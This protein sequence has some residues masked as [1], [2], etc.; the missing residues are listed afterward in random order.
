MKKNINFAFLSLV[1]L[2]LARIGYLAVTHRIAPHDTFYRF[3]SQYFFLS[4][5][6]QTGE[7]PF[8]NPYIN[9][10][11]PTTYNHLVGGF[12]GILTYSLFL[13]GA[14]IENVNAL[15]IFYLGYFVDEMVLL[16]GAWFL[17]ERYFA[18][19]LTQWFVCASIMS[20]SLWMGP[21][22]F[23][24]Q[25]YYALPLILHLL[26]TFLE[27][28]KWRYLFL[29]ANLWFIQLAGNLGYFIPISSLTIFLYWLFYVSFNTR[30]TGRQ[31]K[32]LRWNG[33]C[34][35]CLTGIALS[36]GCMVHIFQAGSADHFI[37]IAAGRDARAVVDLPTFLQ[38]GVDTKNLLRWLELFLGV[39][40]ALDFTLY[41][42]ILAVPMIA[43]ALV[44]NFNNKSKPI[45]SLILVLVLFSRATVVSEFFYHVWP[46]MKYFRH[47][48][49]I[50]P[51]IKIFLCFLAGFGFEAIFIRRRFLQYPPGKY[52]VFLPLIGLSLAAS[53][54]LGYLSHIPDRYQEA[55]DFM[56]ISVF[57]GWKWPHKADSP[58]NLYSFQ[59]TGMAIKFY[60][61]TLVLTFLL[62]VSSGKYHKPLLIFITVFH[63]L[64]VYSY[65]FLETR[66]RTFPVDG[67]I[68][69]QLRYQDLKY[70]PGRKQWSWDEQ[71]RKK[72]LLELDKMHSAVTDSVFAFVF[73]DERW[74][75]ARTDQWLQPLD[76][77]MK[78]YWG[79][80][81]GAK[82][83]GGRDMDL[84]WGS[85]NFPLG[86]P[87]ARKLSGFD[88]EK[89]QLFS[90]AAIIPDESDL[91]KAITDPR[92]QGDR[93]FVSPHSG[94]EP[95]GAREWLPQEDP[96]ANDRLDVPFRV[97]QFDANHVV[98]RTNVPH[99]G[100]WLFYSDVYHPGWQATVNREPRK[101]YPANIA[102]KAVPL[103][104]GDNEVHF[105]FYPKGLAFVL[106][107]ISLNCLFWFCYVGFSFVT[108]S[109]EKEVVI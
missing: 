66:K 53:C 13:V 103:D 24:F 56:Q 80:N 83:K 36:A 91:A 105:Y 39:S 63:F 55:F 45:L 9:L 106:K 73:S 19:R 86:H 30:E 18:S 94:A 109:R 26:H 74:F 7:L 32:A 29:A 75:Q 10:G 34:V 84:F 58:V 79:T 95:K 69:G 72:L 54:Q 28:Q 5:L 31:V 14:L 20:S 67:E 93:L 6:V 22:F 62:F 85:V 98:I 87:G 42:G 27:T 88:R 8:W 81:A 48:F 16:L 41:V 50:S 2:S 12:G 100:A 89:I 108:L 68:Y 57:A 47:L 43:A 97:E 11:S 92:Y 40:L 65:S 64:D 71:P 59:F 1:F 37:S 76:K 70:N 61:L 23:N 15:W 102:Y 38:F 17:S 3:T 35:L 46:C 4:N 21:A 107:L 101:I 33:A 44:F 82:E 90:K 49:N 96:G 104:A 51:L 60:I 25:L 78:A 52:W 99:D 77:F